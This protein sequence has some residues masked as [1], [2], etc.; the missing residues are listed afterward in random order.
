MRFVKRQIAEPIDLGNCTFTIARLE[1][2]QVLQQ[3]WMSIE[4][5]GATMKEV[6]M[7]FEQAISY[8]KPSK[9]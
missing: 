7:S 8:V 6:G 4:A 1:E 2:V 5:D 3:W 9:S